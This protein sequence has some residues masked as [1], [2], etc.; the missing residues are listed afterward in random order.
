[1]NLCGKMKSVS[2]ALSQLF[3]KMRDDF[4]PATKKVIAARVGYRCANPDCRAWTSAP[5]VDP[6]RAYNQGKAAHITAASPGGPRFDPSLTSEQRKQATNGIWLCTSCADRVDNA[7]SDFSVELLQQWKSSAEDYTLQQ[8]HRPLSE[9]DD[10]FAVVSRPVRF[11]L[12]TCV[13]KDGKPI[14]YASIFDPENGDVA[15]YANPAFVIRFLIQKNPKLGSVVMNRI[16]CKVHWR[17]DLA[18]YQHL[19]YALPCETSLYLLE[20]DDP[21]AGAGDTFIAE[22]YFDASERPATAMKYAPL[23]LSAEIADTIDVRFNAK[24]Q[25]LY[26]IRVDVVVNHGVDEQ[27]LPLGSAE[28]FFEKPDF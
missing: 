22:R 13:I 10:I 27:T 16:Q 25:G 3:D 18:D 4:T 21:K 20:I 24:R 11:G 9:L 28:V 2:G 26:S 17:Q 15:F 8:F 5:Q 6:G 7:K 19:A 14:P 23:L 12:E 1:M